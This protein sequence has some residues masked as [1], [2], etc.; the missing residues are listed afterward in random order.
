MMKINELF[1]TELSFRGVLRGFWCCE[2]TLNR[3][4]N[5]HGAQNTIELETNCVS[6][7]F[8]EP[9]HFTKLLNNFAKLIRNFF[10]IQFSSET[11]NY[12]TKIN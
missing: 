1:A 9:S 3:H 4:L 7:S 6:F 8:L 12:K 5:K 11:Q 10:F 2:N